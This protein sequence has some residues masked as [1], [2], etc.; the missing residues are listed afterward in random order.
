M[1]SVP[2]ELE[3][4]GPV[5]VVRFTTR[6]LLDQAEVDGVRQ[7]LLRLAGDPGR[8]RLLLDFRAVEAL[9]SAVLAVLL[10][11]RG[12]LQKVGGRLAL[13]ELRPDVREVF[14]IAGLEGP[15]NVCATEQEALASLAD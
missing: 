2:L 12:R 3:E 13:C 8:G 6:R 9:T 7:A 5:S 10:S 14:A 1:S 15:L 11:L 4:V